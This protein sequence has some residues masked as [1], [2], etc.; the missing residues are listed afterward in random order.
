MSKAKVQFWG[1]E[2]Q[3]AFRSSWPTPLQPQ[4]YILF[5]YILIVYML[6]FKAVLISYWSVL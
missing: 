5:V 3:V 4:I 6:I 1:G 2:A